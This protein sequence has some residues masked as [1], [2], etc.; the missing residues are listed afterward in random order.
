MCSACLVPKLVVFRSIMMA[1]LMRPD[2]PLTGDSVHIIIM[3]PLTTHCIMWQLSTAAHVKSIT[4]T[5]TE[6]VTCFT[7]YEQHNG[8]YKTMRTVREK[9]NSG[10]NHGSHGWSTV[11]GPIH[12]VMKSSF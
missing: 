11:R 3:Q 10:L 6:I 9:I 7:A 12:V 5:L 1:G 2:S 4:L 8:N